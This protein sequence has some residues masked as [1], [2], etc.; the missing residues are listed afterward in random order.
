MN[1][2]KC[3]P[4]EI[5]GK[6]S[7]SKRSHSG[8]SQ[9]TITHVGSPVNPT[10]AKALATKLLKKPSIQTACNAI[11]NATIDSL[12]PIGIQTAP[13]PTKQSRPSDDVQ[14][15]TQNKQTLEVGKSGKGTQNPIRDDDSPNR[16]PSK[17]NLPNGN[18]I[19]TK[20]VR[21]WIE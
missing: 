10:T 21:I 1:N 14:P 7:Y 12:S 5:S 20:S 9:S 4:Q 17:Q 3:T 11:K 8:D 2:T 13:M 6:A 18:D 19:T 15:T 16:R